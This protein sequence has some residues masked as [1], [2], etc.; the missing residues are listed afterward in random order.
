MTSMT[1]VRDSCSMA[2]KFVN[3]YKQHLSFQ[4]DCQGENAVHFCVI[5]LSIDFHLVFLFRYG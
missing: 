3:G 1:L 4:T 2:D 5:W